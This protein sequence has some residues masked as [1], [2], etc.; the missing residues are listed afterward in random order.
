MFLGI[1]W[2]LLAPSNVRHDETVSA[3]KITVTGRDVTWEVDVSRALLEGIVRFPAEPL[4]LQES[5]LASVKG[6]IAEALRKGLSLR[7]NGHELASQ[8]G[9]LRAEQFP[10][11]TTG[12]LYIARFHLDFR[13]HAPEDLRELTLGLRFFEDRMKYHRALVTIE[14]DGHVRDFT[15][16]GP[17]E[18]SVAYDRLAPTFWGTARY[19]VLGGLRRFLAAYDTIAFMIALLVLAGR[20]GERARIA[21]SAAVG[22]LLAYFFAASFPMRLSPGLVGALAAASSVYVAAENFWVLDGRF[23]WGI[24]FG[25]GLLHGLELG[26]SYLRRSADEAGSGSGPAVWYAVGLLGGLLSVLLV[27]W[28]I[29]S[30]LE[31]GRSGSGAAEP[32][33]AAVRAVSAAAL[34]VGASALFERLT[35]MALLSRW[36]RE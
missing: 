20:P 28:P 16:I 32:R 17:G 11:V 1:L 21:A 33:R 24:A 22:I 31:R 26:W 8:V 36:W 18:V 14:W 9:A 12:Q 7:G 34:A 30:L 2:V 13:F 35:G 23:R 29:F 10:F 25:L 6:A 19:F 5:D 3:S 27:F 4:D 15:K